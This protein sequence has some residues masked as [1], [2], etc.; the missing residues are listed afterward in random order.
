[1]KTL[2]IIGYSLLAIGAVVGGYLFYK[3]TKKSSGDQTP[4]GMGGNGAGSGSN[5]PNN[6]ADA[7]VDLKPYV[8]PPGSKVPQLVVANKSNIAPDTPTVAFT[9][10]SDF[11]K[12]YFGDYSTRMIKFQADV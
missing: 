5:A 4:T 8:P 2:P 11:F 6:D 3:R 1:M 7:R 10:D 12:T 9:G